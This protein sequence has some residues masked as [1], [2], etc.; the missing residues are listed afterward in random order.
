MV[1][2]PMG[3][4]H[5]NGLNVELLAQRLKRLALL[6]GRHARIDHRGLPI[7]VIDEISL[8]SKDIACEGMH[9]AA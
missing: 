6:R 7:S 4:Q 9:H 2:M 5:L 8:L 3:Q 1:Q